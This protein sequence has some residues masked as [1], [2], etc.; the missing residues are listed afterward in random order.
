MPDAEDEKI[1]AGDTHG[2]D[3]GR[4]EEEPTVV[5]GDHEGNELPSEQQE[6]GERLALIQRTIEM[7]RLVERAV[8]DVPS[9]VD[10]AS[11]ESDTMAPLR[12][13]DEYFERFKQLKQDFAIQ[14]KVVE[15]LTKEIGETCGEVRAYLSDVMKRLDQIIPEF[16]QLHHLIGNYHDA[17]YRLQRIFAEINQAP[18]E[19]ERAL[20]AEERAES[21]D[22]LF[23]RADGQDQ[24]AFSL[25]RKLLGKWR[26]KQEIQRAEAES[27]R[28]RGRLSRL[29]G[30]SM[31][32]YKMEVTNRSLFEARSVGEGVV[33]TI[34]EDYLS[35]L[36]SLHGRLKEF[37]RR[38][39]PR[40]LIPEL[41]EEQLSA[42]DQFVVDGYI[43]RMLTED[44]VRIDEFDIKQERD[45]IYEFIREVRHLGPG[46]SLNSFTFGEPDEVTEKRDELKKRLEEFPYDVKDRIL[47]PLVSYSSFPEQ[48]DLASAFPRALQSSQKYTSLL[49]EAHKVVGVRP[50]SLLQSRLDVFEEYLPPD[51]VKKISHEFWRVLEKCPE[52]RAAVGE[53]AVDRAGELYA[54]EIKRRVLTTPEHTDTSVDFGYRMYEYDGPEFAEYNI[55]NAWRESGNS[56][57]QPFLS[58][59]VQDSRQT[60]LFRYIERQSEETLQRI[61]EKNPAL[62]R[63]IELVKAHP[64]TFGDSYLRDAEG[65]LEWN[66]PNPIHHEIRKNLTDS[67]FALLQRDTLEDQFFAL[68]VLGDDPAILPASVYERLGQ[69]FAARSDKRFKGELVSAVLDHARRSS[70]PESIRFLAERMDLLSKEHRERLVFAKPSLFTNAFD[71]SITPETHDMIAKLLGVSGK[72]LDDMRD[73]YLMAFQPG[74]NEHAYRGFSFQYG[75]PDT[76]AY[77]AQNKEA[78]LESLAQIRQSF[79]EYRPSLSYWNERSDRGEETRRPPDVG[80]EFV[81]NAV[82]HGQQKEAFLAHIKVHDDLPPGMTQ[83]FH[84]LFKMEGPLEKT[85]ERLLS[86][87]RFQL[88]DSLSQGLKNYLYERWMLERMAHMSHESFTAFVGFVREMDKATVWSEVRRFIS[89]AEKL[90]LIDLNRPEDLKQV[91]GFI[92][93]FGTSASH[94]LFEYYTGLHRGVAIPAELQELG[95]KSVG[96][97]GV[98]ELRGAIRN[99]R[100]KLVS[101]DTVE[102]P[103]NPLVGSIVAT[104]LRFETSQWTRREKGVGD[105]LKQLR[106]DQESAAIEP[107]PKEYT[108]GTMNVERL[109]ID[110]MKAFEFSDGFRGRYRQLAESFNMVQQGKNVKDT[111]ILVRDQVT[112]QLDGELAEI[113]HKITKAKEEGRPAKAI[114]GMERKQQELNILRITVVSADG[115]KRLLEVLLSYDKKEND[116]TTQALRQLLLVHAHE[117]NPHYS[118]DIAMVS[119]TEATREGAQQMMTYVEDLLMAEALPHLKLDKA[120][121]KRVKE[122]FNFTA[123]EEELKRL[124]QFARRGYQEITC[125]PSRGVLAEF[126]GYYGDAC[127]T[128]QDAIVRNNPEMVAVA[129]VNNF[130]DPSNERVMGSVLLFERTINGEKALVVRGMNPMQNVVTELSSSSF[131]QEFMKY[132]MPIAKKRGVKKIVA[133][134]GVP[135]TLTNRP[136]IDTAYRGLYGGNPGR[137][138]DKEMNFNDYRFD[139]VVELIDLSHET[140]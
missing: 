48:L 21:I 50:H 70:D 96:T 83:A 54:Q 33:R 125:V 108:M 133:P 67:A 43:E 9:R 30:G 79:S 100:K 72:Q 3:Q 56:G 86:C 135:G 68:A 121:A 114:E 84:R 97:E 2:S 90:E 75:D 65:K 24:R 120:G 22:E 7:V 107:L 88:D 61:A 78:F 45:D 53:E 91:A 39:I 66:K 105:M 60:M 29:P 80:E 8:G 58:I 103:H 132:V 55:I 64:D 124:E 95:I 134:I 98:N 87:I 6:Y 122:I 62:G 16:R 73:I 92:R 18:K 15:A 51:Y 69:L 12:P 113:T 20:L 119:A 82:S 17:V 49:R 112:H 139:Q 106:L 76:F 99:I 129:F 123:F 25:R 11:V 59:H 19:A 77:L 127:W 52:F 63:V 117:V 110:R 128:R 138:L 38:D 31:Y 57:E 104:L 28:L 42:I 23:E 102:H 34:E 81:D 131:I 14:K 116:I 36:K 126:S 94:Q 109:D 26:N 85:T 13:A 5:E 137:K 27:G 32:D 111:T 44:L 74:E 35:Q 4:V 71:K 130:G 89:E 1:N 136:G 93:E 40:E 10:S 37:D 41:T 140:S 46:T 115:M 47:R 101:E 118:G